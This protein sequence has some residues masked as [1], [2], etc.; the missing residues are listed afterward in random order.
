MA[1][2][3]PGFAP[4]GGVS[5]ADLS[6]HQ[7]KFVKM[8]STGI[9][10]ATSGTDVVVGVLQNKP[11]TGQVCEL[12]AVGQS[13]VIAGAAITQ[14]AG[15][16]SDSLGRAITATSTNFIQGVSWQGAGALGDVTTVLLD[17]QGKL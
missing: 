9:N 4:G 6:T 1:F 7:F 17:K 2:E 11:T 14:G 16:M 13:K 8:T 12:M 15:V 5:A 3:I 10:L